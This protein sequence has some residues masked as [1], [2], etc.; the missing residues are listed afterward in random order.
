MN[1]YIDRHIHNT[2]D[3]RCVF[4]NDVLSDPICGVEKVLHLHHP[5][6]SVP[7]IVYENTPI[8]INT[9]SGTWGVPSVFILAHITDIDVLTYLRSLPGVTDVVGDDTI[10]MWI[11]KIELSRMKKIITEIRHTYLFSLIPT[12]ECLIYESTIDGS[13]RD[14]IWWCR[15]RSIDKI[16]IDTTHIN[17]NSMVMSNTYVHRRGVSPPLY[18]RMYGMDDEKYILIDL[19]AGAFCGLAN[20]LLSLVYALLIGVCS[21]RT[22]VVTGFYPTYN[23]TDTVH[24][25]EAIDL[26]QYNLILSKYNTRVCDIRDIGELPWVPIQTITDV[27]SPLDVA[28]KIYDYPYVRAHIQCLDFDVF[29]EVPRDSMCRSIYLDMKRSII[30]NKDLESL[31]DVRPTMS[32]HLRI[33]NDMINHLHKYKEGFDETSY[34]E[35]M[36]R[37]CKD[38]IGKIHISTGLCKYNNKYNYILEELKREKDISTMKSIGRGREFDAMLDMIACLKSD[39]FIG[40]G[41]EENG[42]VYTTVSTFSSY[43]G[44]ILLSRGKKV[45]LIET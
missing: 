41:K 14:E 38:S 15:S 20:Q 39:H 13:I 34:V 27:T 40:L 28:T 6:L 45:T 1:K 11:G 22:V 10:I 24:I 16:F 37:P 36:Y 32:I 4:Y 26:V 25:G 12:L 30:F 9:D 29:G 31:V 33:E 18:L 3:L 42:V 17:M 43:I 44:D 35:S 2:V 21:G 5:I 8:I 23:K 7:V 19:N